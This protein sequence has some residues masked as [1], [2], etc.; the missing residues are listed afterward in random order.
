MSVE[1]GKVDRKRARVL[2]V[3]MKDEDR[4]RA[5]AD[6][7]AHWKRKR[8]KRGKHML[9]GRDDIAE[10]VASAR[11][12][13]RETNHGYVA[14][15]EVAMPEPKGEFRRTLRW[16][17]VAARA[18][19]ELRVA[20]QLVL[21]AAELDAIGEREWMVEQGAPLQRSRT[22][23]KY[24]R[25]VRKALAKEKRELRAVLAKKTYPEQA[26]FAL[27]ER[28]LATARAFNREKPIANF[29][30]PRLSERSIRLAMLIRN[31]MTGA[32]GRVWLAGN[33]RMRPLLLSHEEADAIGYALPRATEEL[34][35]RKR[36]DKRASKTCEYRSGSVYAYTS[37]RILDDGQRDMRVGQLRAVQALTADSLPTARV[38]VRGE[39]RHVKPDTGAQYSVA[40]E[41]WI[42]LGVR[43]NL[44]P[45]VDYVEG[46]TGVVTKVLGVWRFRLRTQ[47]E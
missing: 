9:H 35:N 23:R 18:L 25:R 17:A 39:R 6:E 7:A 41:A 1:L 12:P 14:E 42:T 28:I 33:L 15:C 16:S 8:R 38:E 26:Y 47:Y 36:A 30:L 2:F 43:L 3:R 46:F 29:G 5:R 27:V 37:V 21:A 40:G 19:N 24:E 31:S 20:R 10:V 4:A 11:V 32:F 45:P 13:K 44:L 34:L 22:R